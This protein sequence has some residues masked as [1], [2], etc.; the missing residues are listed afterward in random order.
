MNDFIVVSNSL[1]RNVP[2]ISWCMNTWCTIGVTC[3]NSLGDETSWEQLCQSW[4]EVLTPFPIPISAPLLYACDS[5]CES[6]ASCFC[7]HFS[8][9]HH[10]LFTCWTGGPT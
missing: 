5:A 3:W 4:I 8:L 1:M 7:R 2:H 9:C 6:S 10:G